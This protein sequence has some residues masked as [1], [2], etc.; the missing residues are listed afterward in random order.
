MYRPPPLRGRSSLKGKKVLLI[1]SCQATREVRTAI[2]RD[3]GIEVH[4]AEHFS[5]ARFLWRPH[6]FDLVMLDV[7]RYSPGEILE[8]YEQIRDAHPE[9]RFAFIA[10]PPKYLSPEWPVEIIAPDAARDQ[11]QQTVQRFA[12]AA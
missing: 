11:W 6:T 8:Y 12:R 7:R 1:D 10:G 2:F 3:H 4:E 9:Q 5:A